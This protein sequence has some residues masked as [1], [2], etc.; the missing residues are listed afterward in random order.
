MSMEHWRLE[1]LAKGNSA[2]AKIA[3]GLIDQFGDI[4]LPSTKETQSSPQLVEQ[5][6]KI[7]N[8]FF[9][10]EIPVVAPPSELFET[11]KVAEREG[12]GR[13]FE[14]IYFPKVEFR[15]EG[16]YPGWQV[17]PERWYWEQISAGKISKDAA[18]LGGYWGLFDNSRRPDYDN[19]KQMFQEDPLAPILSRARK[20][21]R[22]ATPNFVRNIPEDSRF[23]VSPNEQDQTVFPAL[24][25]ILKLPE[26]AAIMRRPTEMEFN[27]AGNL[28][29]PHLGEANTWEWLHDKFGVGGRLIGG[30]SDYGGVTD[31]D[32]YW[33]DNRHDNIAFRPLVVF[34]P[35]P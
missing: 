8:A 35:K 4:P 6:R 19:G 24:R 1:Q 32:C 18:N 22:I 7:L 15:Q 20:E 28:R 10:K 27:F 25:K 3:E 26:S 29:H 13:I 14:P 31:V 17:K 16:N 33:S 12:F 2:A 11:L 34:S 5:E 23:A 30:N 9:G 21:G